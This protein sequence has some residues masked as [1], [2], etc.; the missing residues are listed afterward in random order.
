MNDDK[1]FFTR[2]MNY[3]HSNSSI[4]KNFQNNFYPVYISKIVNGRK[5]LVPRCMYVDFT[6][7]ECRRIASPTVRSS[8]VNCYERQGCTSLELV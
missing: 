1:I 3:S 8:M 6:V 5:K 4:Q 7:D 2:S